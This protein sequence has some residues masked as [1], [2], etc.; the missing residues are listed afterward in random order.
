M[1]VL[2]RRPGRS[3]REV[4]DAVGA[5]HIGGFGESC[6]FRLH[7]AR[8]P[9]IQ[10]AKKSKLVLLRSAFACHGSDPAMCEFAYHQILRFY[11]RAPRFN[12]VTVN[13]RHSIR[14][15]SKRQR[16]VG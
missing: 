11:E 5:A 6:V 8:K 4:A 7:P 16:R 15:K 12:I 1:S 9:H 3:P 13:H 2:W 14:V 10:S